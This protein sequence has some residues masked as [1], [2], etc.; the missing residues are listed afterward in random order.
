MMGGY[1]ID[2]SKKSNVVQFMVDTFNE[3]EEFSVV[4]TPEGTR[5][6]NPDWKTGFYHIAKNANIPIVQGGFDYSKKVVTIF[7]PFYVGE[8]AEGTIELIKERARKIK[9]KYPKQG[10]L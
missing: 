4:I 2:R 8:T 7:D 1:P 10:V 5:A 6:H 3:H 9:G